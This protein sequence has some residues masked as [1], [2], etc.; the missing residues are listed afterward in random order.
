MFKLIKEQSNA[1]RNVMI[2]LTVC[3]GLSAL[4]IIWLGLTSVAVGLSKWHQKGFWFPSLVGAVL[5]LGG[6][7][8]LI[9]TI[10]LLSR[11]DSDKLKGV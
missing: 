3:L 2:A 6:N 10:R 8:I 11:D 4:F 1:R 5:L 7:R 9:T